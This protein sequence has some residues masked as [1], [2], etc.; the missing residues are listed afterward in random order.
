ML[1]K[2]NRLH[3]AV[4][5]FS[6]R[7]Q[8]TSKCGKNKKVV[9]LPHFDVIVI[10]YWTDARRHGIY[11][12]YITTKQTTTDKPFSFISKSFSESRPLPT[13]TNTKKAIW[14]NLLQRK[15]NWTA[16]STNL[17][18]NAGSVKSIFVITAVLWAEK[19]ARC[20]EYRRGWKVRS[21]N[22]R[23]RSTLKAIRFEFWMKGALVTAKAPRRLAIVLQL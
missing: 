16:K 14:R 3:V 22:L 7:S 20:F 6:N 2:T 15:Q 13:L 17:K 11:L 4:S 19:L 23:L 18:E 5:L 9:F 8:V 10:Y 1:Y 21:E 12:F